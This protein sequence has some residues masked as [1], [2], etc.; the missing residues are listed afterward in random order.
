MSDS[1][2]KVRARILDAAAELFSTYGFSGTKLS[3]VAK[4]AGVSSAKVRKLTGGRAELFEE[5]ITTRSH[6]SAASAVA[7]A[8]QDPGSAPPLA[9][10]LAV[11]QDV[12]ENPQNS[13]DILELEALTRA[14]IDEQVRLV[15]TGRI[16]L[17][18]ENAEELVSRIRASGGLDADVSDNV[19]VTMTMALS[20]GLAMLEPVLEGKPSVKQWNTLVAKMGAALISQDQDVDSDFMTGRN[21]R[22]R[23]DI[24]EQPGTLARLVRMLGALHAYTVGVGL[25]GSE[26]GYRTIDAAIVAPKGVTEDVLR[27]AAQSVGRNVHIGPGNKE[28]AEDLPTRVLDGATAMVS[29]PELAPLAAAKLVEA[30]SV[31]VTDATEGEDDTP[32]VLR[33]QWTPDQHVVLH[34]DWAPF[35]DAERTR[36]SAFLRLSSAIA[37]STGNEEAAGWVE[38]VKDGTVWIRLARPEDAEAVAEMHDR[39]SEQSRYQRYFSLA[40]WH[41]ERLHRLSG[42]HRGATLVVMSEDGKIVG[43]G[44]VFPDTSEGEG[45]AEIAMIIEDAYQGKGIGTKLLQALVFLA[46]R[47]EFTEIVASVLADNKAMIGLL[48]STGLVWEVTVDDG[49]SHMR[50]PLPPRPLGED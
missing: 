31:E 4:A 22:V 7:Q 19:I 2:E 18:R 36:A 48:K 14:H 33:L 9:V 37:T 17:R 41:G 46:M 35:A 30:T 43:L 20:V 44:N 16:L 32:Y 15:E 5:V 24:P 1:D 29:R 12:Y 26:D 3:M 28:D 6:S 13:W 21:W 27:A 11:A 47:L 40:D 25:I 23:V 42:G 39:C 49:V 8:L 38:T 50:A 45:A 10:M 34:R